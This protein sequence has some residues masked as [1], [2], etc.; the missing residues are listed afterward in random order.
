M[1]K[2]IHAIAVSALVLSGC[3]KSAS[4][5]AGAY[6]S[7]MIYAQW[8]CAQIDAEEQALQ[9]RV[10][11]MAK[12]QDDA[13]TRDAVAMGI[14]LVLF[15]PALFVLAA[16]DDEAQL[17]V[18]KGQHDALLA[19]RLSKQCPTA[20][21]TQVAGADMDPAADGDDAAATQAEAPIGGPRPLEGE[22]LAAF[23]AEQMRGYC[24]Q[25]WETRVAADGR[26]EFNPCTRR[27]AFM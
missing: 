10:M 8:S 22:R 14:G 1:P 7:P 5:V 13:A 25:T 23:S 21:M 15:W 18:L 26:T 16:G 9:S 2:L 27:D 19:A 3:A 24:A 6:Q 20:P 12:K 4:N 17:S 11:V